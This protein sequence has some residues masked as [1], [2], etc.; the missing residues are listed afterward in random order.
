MAERDEEA[1]RTRLSCSLRLSLISTSRTLDDIDPRLSFTTF[2][3]RA[4]L[5]SA[6]PKPKKS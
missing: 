5:L 6:E 2:A 3:Q 4:G 1:V